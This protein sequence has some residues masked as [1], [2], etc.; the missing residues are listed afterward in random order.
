M[1]KKKKIPM[2]KKKNQIL[3]PGT[4]IIYLPNLKRPEVLRK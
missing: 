1:N 3:V 4:I 2:I